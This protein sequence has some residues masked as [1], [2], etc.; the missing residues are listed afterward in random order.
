MRFLITG[1]AGFIGLNLVKFILSKQ[2]HEILILDKVTYAS[3]FDYL[4]TLLDSNKNITFQK[5]DVSDFD[6]VS[7]AID[8]FRPHKIMHLAAE[9]HVDRSISNSNIFLKSNIIGTYT[10]LEAS[11]IFYEKLG[12]DEKQEFIFHHISTD[13]VFGDLSFDDVPFLETSPY[14]PS[15]PYA[16]SKA[17]ADHLVRAWSRTYRLPSVITNCSNNYGPFQHREK[18]IPLCIDNALKGIEIPIYGDGLQ[19]RDW[20]YVWDHAEALYEVATN[21]NVGET[22]NIGSNNELTNISVV[23]LICDLLDREIIKK[24]KNIRSFHDLI[25]HVSDRPGHDLRYAIN[26]SKINNHLNWTAK[27]SFEEGILTTIK[28]Y[29]KD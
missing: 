7:T 17:S 21:G 16:A 12:K 8:K 27:T 20:L 22:Y 29:I 10:M 26:P 9:T 3:N 23:K 5:V 14:K 1:G 6:S 25:K 11:K 24:P 19:I 4:E 28:W 18:L 15:S 13:E 2:N